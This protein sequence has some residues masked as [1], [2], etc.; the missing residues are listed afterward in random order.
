M[1]EDKGATTN[2]N[3]WLVKG[4]KVAEVELTQGIEPIDA[5]GYTGLHLLVKHQG[6]PLGF[7]TLV[8]PGQAIGNGRDAAPYDYGVFW[9]D[10]RQY[11]VLTTQYSLFSGK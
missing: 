8:E 6:T 5:T 3:A 10:G 2:L 7:V 4:K 1:P 11:S 9:V